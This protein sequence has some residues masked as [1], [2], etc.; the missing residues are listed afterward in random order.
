[1]IAQISRM[2]S[3]DVANRLFDAVETLTWR[4]ANLQPD[5]FRRLGTAPMK[6]W[7]RRVDIP[8]ALQGLRSMQY[9]RRNGRLRRAA[10]GLDVRRN[11]AV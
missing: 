11:K 10:L 5:D 2:S 1:M 3:K 7:E 9:V 8:R 6:L 4:A